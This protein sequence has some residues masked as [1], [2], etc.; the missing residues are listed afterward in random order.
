SAKSLQLLR[1]AAGRFLRAQNDYT[2]SAESHQTPERLEQLRVMYHY[3]EK[4]YEQFSDD[5]VA[6]DV[7]D[8]VWT[9]QKAQAGAQRLGIAK[10]EAPEA[11]QPTET[12]A[13][14]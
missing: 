7:G 9:I 13:A 14:K 4:L 2:R 3:A 8:A 11:S 1:A 12:A 5:F 6:K 10:I